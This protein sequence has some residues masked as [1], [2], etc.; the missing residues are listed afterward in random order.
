MAYFTCNI[1]NN[2]LIFH[3]IPLARGSPLDPAC[4]TSRSWIQG[5][6]LVIP[7]ISHRWE[8]FSS[9]S[10]SRS[11]PSGKRL[12]SYGKSLFLKKFMAKSTISTGPILHFWPILL[13]FALVP[14]WTPGELWPFRSYR[15]P[16][17]QAPKRPR[18]ERAKREP[19]VVAHPP[20]L[21][22]HLIATHVDPPGDGKHKTNWGFIVKTYYIIDILG[23]Q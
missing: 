7:L 23:I 16:T 14:G 1:S 10:S 3:R 9:V 22:D 18:F 19:H 5:I 13:L 21:D 4:R 8:I 2:I 17:P 20:L 12:H 11:L 6:W 15:R